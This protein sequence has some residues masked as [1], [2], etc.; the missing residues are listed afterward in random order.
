MKVITIIENDNIT[1][2]K[3]GTVEI[4]D[5]PS[6]IENDARRAF[7][8]VQKTRAARVRRNRAENTKQ[9]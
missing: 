8:R 6:N 9:K 2:V 5:V 3:Y 4:P 1:G 7:E